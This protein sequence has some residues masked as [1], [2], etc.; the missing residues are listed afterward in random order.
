ME[1]QEHPNNAGEIVN[2]YTLPE[3]IMWHPIKLNIY[4]PPTQR[5]KSKIYTLEKYMQ[6]CIWMYVQECSQ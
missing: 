4:V 2:W 1:Q 3:N 5:F 6:M